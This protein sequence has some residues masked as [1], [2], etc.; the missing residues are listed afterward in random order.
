VT[1]LPGWL[2]R[3]AA[4]L[5]T[6]AHDLTGRGSPRPTAVAPAPGDYLGHATA[7]MAVLH[8]W[9]KPSTGLWRTT[10]WWNAA[11]LLTTTI[12]HATVAASSEWNDLVATT[13]ERNRGAYRGNF[14]NDYYDDAGWWALAWLRAWDLTRRDRYLDT[15]R[16]IFADLTEA[17][18]GTCAGGVWWSRARGYKNAIAN[19]LFMS[20]AAGLHLRTSSI[21]YLD[22]ARRSWDWFEASGMRNAEGLINDGLRDCVNNGLTTW[23]YNQGVILGGLVALHHA[24]RD[25]ALLQ[26]ADAIADAATQ[27]LVDPAGVL[28]EP[29]TTPDQDQ[30]QFK[31]I[32]TRNLATLHEATRRDR[33]AAFL[34]HNA[35]AIL[36]NA[37]DSSGRYA[38]TWTATAAGPNPTTAATHAS[39]LDT[40]VAAA[41]THPR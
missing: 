19:E 16:A 39:A 1:P 35:D 41:R 34:R 36:T 18:D 22:W 11:N 28:T 33:H 30:V 26:E 4:W 25:P 5:A 3:G 2:A 29:S 20:V 12:D 15:A 8:R 31:G 14:C 32:F 17:W 10:G 38:F 7:G 23:T 21:E 9:Y 6:R 40:V 24:T 27:K 37:R 13:F